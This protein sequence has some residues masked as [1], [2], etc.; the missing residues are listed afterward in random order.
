MKEAILKIG[1]Y[2]IFIVFEVLAVASEILFLALLFII[3]TGI[4][5]LLK[6]TFGEIF[7]QSCL[8]LGIA[9]VSVAFIYR[10]KFQKKFEAICRIKS[11]N[12][13]HQFKKLSYF[14]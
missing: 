3:P 9:L 1:C 2:T 7:S 12:L 14:Q 10:K 4:G 11:A 5:A 13:I 6:S 8:V